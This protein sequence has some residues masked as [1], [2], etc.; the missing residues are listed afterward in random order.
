MAERHNP[1]REVAISWHI[2]LRDGCAEDWEAFMLWLEISPDH[3]AAY[4]A[5]VLADEGIEDFLETPENVAANDDEPSPNSYGGRKRWF[6]G[7]SIAAAIAFAV[8]IASSPSADLYDI[9]TGVGERR[10]IALG[11]D[12][13]VT[14]NGST[15]ITLDRNDRRFASLESGEAI[16]TIKHDEDAPFVVDLGSNKVQDV[17]TVFNIIRNGKDIR[18]EVAEGEVVYNPGRNGQALVAGQLL[19]D[20]AE[21]V[22]VRRINPAQVGRWQQGRLTFHAAPLSMVA[23]DL[24]R[25]LGTRVS[26]DPK[27]SGRQFSGTIQLEQDQKLLFRRLENLLAVEAKQSE[28]GWKLN[29]SGRAGE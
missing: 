28:N 12:S 7:L 2:R 8:V 6:A 26:L 27:L 25:N 14:L 3:A 5:V 1:L 9:E 11:P 19:H 20:N 29:A 16:F 10:T 18:V 23:A 15:K 21:K 17:G 13:S 22:S 24:A 4:D